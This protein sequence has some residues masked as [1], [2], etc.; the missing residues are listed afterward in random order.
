MC[1]EMHVQSTVRFKSFGIAG[2]YREL[3]C[4]SFLSCLILVCTPALPAPIVLAASSQFGWRVLCF[5]SSASMQRLG[6]G[7]TEIH[8]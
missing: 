6:S 7:S 4:D 1:Q 3:M 2:S 8:I 5:H